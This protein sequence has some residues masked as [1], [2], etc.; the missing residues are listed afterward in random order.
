MAAMQAAARAMPEAAEPPREAASGAGLKICQLCAVDFTLYHFLRPLMGGLSAQGHDVVGVCSGGALADAARTQ[1]HR[2]EAVA[3]PRRL[4]PT[5]MFAAYRALVRLFRRERFD[6]VH[7]HTPV[8]AFIGRLAAARARVPRVVYTAHGFYFHER[9]GGHRR[10]LFLAAEWVAGRVTDT[11]FT[12]AEED[13][14]TARRYHLCRGGDVVAIGNGSDPAI[15]RPDDD[16]TV[17]AGVRARLGTPETR[18]VVVT[19]SRLVEEKG[20]P[21]LLEALRDVDAELWAIGARLESDHAGSIEAAVA[22][23]AHDP[24]RRDRVRFLGYR[25]DAAELLRAADIFTLPSHRE[26]MPRSIVEA[27]LTGLP[28]VAT[29]IRGAREEVVAE[30]TGLLVP[31][32]DAAALAAALNRLARDAALRRRLGEA[33]LRRAKAHYDEATV[34]ARQIDHLGL[35]DAT[36]AET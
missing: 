31:V 16:G 4:S 22:A 6:I 30:E 12:Q 29:D 24:G 21:E 26:G 28:V 15:F 10:W 25:G 20:Y 18:V 3:I 13:A 17:R 34:V 2:V 36:P 27:M 5:R 14:A 9:M 19:I 1:G 7:V 35:A 8:A 32:G 23:V 11:L 33:G